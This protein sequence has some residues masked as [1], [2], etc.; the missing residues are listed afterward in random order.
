MCFIQ[1]RMRF[2][3]PKMDFTMCTMHFSLCG[4]NFTTYGRYFTTLRMYFS[5]PG[6]HFNPF[7]ICLMPPRMHLTSPND[8][9]QPGKGAFHSAWRTMACDQILRVTL[10]HTYSKAFED[11]AA[12]VGPAF[13]SVHCFLATDKGQAHACELGFDTIL[14]LV[15]A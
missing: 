9:F 1:P 6:A 13:C 11:Y 8:A 14:L 4:I 10:W 15:L 3:L 5:P 12:F 2:T 7:K